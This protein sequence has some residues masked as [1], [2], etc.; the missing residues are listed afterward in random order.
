MNSQ[1]KAVF[2]TSILLVIGYSCFTTV[3]YIS[4]EIETTAFLK[5]I[6][7]VVLACF[8]LDFFFNFF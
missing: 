1:W 8:A 4:F 6:D 5:F 3:L 2:D 7:N